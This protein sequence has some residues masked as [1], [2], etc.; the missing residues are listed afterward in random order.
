MTNRPRLLLL[1]SI[2]I[3]TALPA[4]ANAQGRGRAPV[5]LPDGPG[6][7]IVQSVCS[8][9]H[10]LNMITYDGYS[11]AEWPKVFGTM[12]DL[13]KAQADIVA[14]YLAKNFPD[15]PKLPAV[16]IPGPTKV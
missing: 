9:C 11:R 5:D 2:S 12:V 4:P 7:E 16:V 15:K 13:P 6:K 8:Q 10:G 1:C 14:D 3:C